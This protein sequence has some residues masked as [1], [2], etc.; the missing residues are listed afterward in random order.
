ML[1]KLG[2]TAW[3]LVGLCCV[4]CGSGSGIKPIANLVPI[5]G[6][7][8]YQG[9]PLSAGTISFTP[10][11]PKMG[12]PASATITAGQ[13]SVRTTVDANGLIA[14]DYRVAISSVEGAAA[15]DAIALVAATTQDPKSR[16]PRKSLIPERYAD[17][18]TSLLEVSVKKGMGP[19]KLELTD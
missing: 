1:S 17:L 4:G 13:F 19:L 16:P 14:G 5:A 9:K 11:D 12:Q 7:V 10:K 6:T 8:T 2:L 3:I 18:N 15:T